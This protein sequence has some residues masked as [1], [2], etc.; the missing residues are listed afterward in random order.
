M[1][2]EIKNRFNDA[3]I[4][5]HEQENNS[6]KIT[7]D[8]AVSL[9]ADLSYANLIDASL[10]VANLRDATLRGA[11]L[12]YADLIDACLLCIG[13]MNVICTMQLDQWA[14]G[15]TKDILQIGCQRHPIEKWRNFSDDE[16]SMM[17]Q[18]SLLWWK[19]WKFPLFAIIDERL[20]DLLV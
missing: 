10:R 1:K 16:I 9:R 3:V 7:V 11:N 19:R 15:F 18:G 13:D 12:S 2:I 5:S 17:A 8:I 14:I 4:F 6:I 20:K